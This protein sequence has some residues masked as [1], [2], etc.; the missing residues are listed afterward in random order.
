M[1]KTC[2]SKI[3]SIKHVKILRLDN[4]FTYIIFKFPFKNNVCKII[5]KI[6]YLI[7]LAIKNS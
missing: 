2:H 7:T 6:N 5:T 3:D 1:S 4:Y